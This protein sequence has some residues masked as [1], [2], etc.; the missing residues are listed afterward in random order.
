M[1]INVGIIGCGGISP[2]HI[3]IYSGF[4]E[5]VQ[6]VAVCDI[7][8]EKAENRKQIVRDTYLSREAEHQKRAEEAQS[9]DEKDGYVKLAE[10]CQNAAEVEVKA[11]TSHDELLKDERVDA[12]NIC[13]PPFAHPEPMIAAANA[14]KHVFCEGPI[15]GDLKQADAMIAAARNNKIKFTVQYGTRLSRGSMMAKKAIDDGKLGKILMGKVDVMWYRAQSYYDSGAWRGTWAGERGGATF[16]HGRYAIDL[17]LWLMGEVSEVY[18]QMDTFTHNIELEDCSMSVLR[19]KHGALGQIMASTSAHPGIAPSQ[20]IEI[21]CER[22]AISVIP[23]WNI[24]S[25]D[26][27]YAAQLKQELEVEVPEPAYSGMAGQMK[28][29]IDAIVEDREPYITGESVRPQVEV[30]RGIYKSVATG[31]SARLPLKQ[32]DPFYGSF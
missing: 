3:N 7:V 25:S 28:D 24:G 6:I 9:Q 10:V 15:A 20:R 32:Y 12:V 17:Y 5:E 2:S 1:K 26:E 30:T 11:Y 14:G 8:K 19:F 16:H 4:P 22:A 21:F 31:Q 18:A 13:T 29:F 27:N 23:N